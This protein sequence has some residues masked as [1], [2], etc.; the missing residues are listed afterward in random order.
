MVY[1][2]SCGAANASDAAR[3]FACQRVFSS[4]ATSAQE[5]MPAFLGE[6]YRVLAQVGIGGFGAVYKAFD[7]KADNRLVAIKEI[8]L[9]GLKPQEKID[10]TDTFNREVQILSQLSHPNLPRIHRHFTDADHWYLVMDFIEGRT[11]E[12]N[13]RTSGGRLPLDEGIAIALQLCSVL[14]YLHSYEPPIIFRDLKP[15]NV[16]ITFYRQV[17]LIDFGTARFF[18]PG[19]PRDTIAFGSPGYAAP[20]QY[21]RAQ[22][23]ARSDIFS[24]GA[25]LHTM[26]T[27]NDPAESAFHFALLRSYDP[28]LP[29][30]LERLIAQMVEAEMEKRPESATDVKEQLQRLSSGH[31]RRLYALPG[32]LSSPIY[33]PGTSFGQAPPASWATAT[34]SVVQ[35]QMQLGL[36]VTPPASAKKT[37]KG[38]ISRRKAVPIIVT[39]A[40]AGTTVLGN[41]AGLG[42]KQGLDYQRGRHEYQRPEQ[43]GIETITTYTRH[44]DSVTSVAWSPSGDMVA[45]GS[46]D[47]TAQT[48]SSTTGEPGP[49]FRLHN[50]SINALAWSPDGQRI[51]IAY[52]GL[53][54]VW[55]PGTNDMFFKLNRAEKHAFT[56]IAWSGDSRYVAV[57]ADT[58]EVWAIN[59]TEAPKNI[60]KGHKALITDVSWAPDIYNGSSRYIATSSKDG[61]VHIWNAMSNDLKVG[62]APG[63]GPIDALCWSPD[64]EYIASTSYK[65]A[66]AVQLHETTQGAPIARYTGHT[67][68][69]TT[70]S[71]SPNGKL[72]ASAS[73]D[74][75]VQIWEPMTG[76]TRL[77]YREHTGPVRTVA[78]SPNS[79]TMLVSGGDDRTARVWSIKQ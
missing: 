3:C 56:S 50:G 22:T 33:Q 71:W 25:T 29:S 44:N 28:S 51:A 24:L 21:G 9:R 38:I 14:E 16:M 76:L 40:I 79:T 23:N 15:A 11:L 59:E 4:T 47:K 18:K 31:T 26:F 78:W 32:T 27:G 55:T 13:L 75:T 74:A 73:E 39:L 34:P 62:Y 2:E 10:A 53:W 52:D 46:L 68:A 12:E 8:R 72:L 41:I 65:D 7:T 6:Q 57:A 35:A 49:V 54:Y 63:P 48:W 1:C 58:V 70:L 45:S 61:T 77:T 5:E 30:E 60:Y 19:R 42:G 17:Y 66:S 20:E 64:G 67:A 69:V 36:P 37:G 43:P